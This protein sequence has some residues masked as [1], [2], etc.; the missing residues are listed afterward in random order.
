[1]PPASWPGL[2][3]PSTSCVLERNKKDVDA[4]DKRGHDSAE[5]VQYD[6]NRCV[7]QGTR[8]ICGIA[9]RRLQIEDLVKLGHFDPRIAQSRRELVHSRFLSVGEE[10]APR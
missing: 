5:V 4:R 3:R 6:R 8:T 10:R 2:S 1:M 9:P 7:R